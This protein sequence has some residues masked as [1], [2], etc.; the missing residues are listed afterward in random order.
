MK[1]LNKNK[2]FELKPQGTKHRA[3]MLRKAEMAEH[4]LH[5][6]NQT[7]SRRMADSVLQPRHHQIQSVAANYIFVS[8]S[9]VFNY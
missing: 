9:D 8:P 6:I 3:P 7:R 5:R 1:L 2:A 4:A